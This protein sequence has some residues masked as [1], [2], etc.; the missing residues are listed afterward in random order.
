MG[1]S[2]GFTAPSDW[3]EELDSLLEALDLLHEE[4]T[5]P[6]KVLNSLE[7]ARCATTA[8]DFL[9]ELYSLREAQLFAGRP[10]LPRGDARSGVFV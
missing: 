4:P 1:L 7:L 3:D 10:Q 6:G 5:S 9:E 2:R 8:S